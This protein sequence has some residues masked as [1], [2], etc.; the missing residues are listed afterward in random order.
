MPRELTSHKVN[1]CNDG[2][3]VEAVDGPGPGGASHHYTVTGPP[4]TL[5]PHDPEPAWSQTVKFQNGPLKEAGINGT[6]H[7]VLLAII[8]DRLLGFQSGPYAC[9]ENG[10]ALACVQNAQRILKSRTEARL[11]RGVEGTHK[12]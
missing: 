7:E 3:H 10:E 2:L 12:V 4:P 11:A 5:N 1:G 9:P 8:E 6:T